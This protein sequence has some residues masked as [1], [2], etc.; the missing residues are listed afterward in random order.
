[1][2][3]VCYCA[4]L[5]ASHITCEIPFNNSAS[6]SVYNNQYK[7]SAHS[8]QKNDEIENSCKYACLYF[9]SLNEES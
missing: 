9:M 1:M 4:I 5:E 8:S 3:D 7:F 2:P 6:F